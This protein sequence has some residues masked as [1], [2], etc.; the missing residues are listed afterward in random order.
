M[1][2]FIFEIGTKNPG[3]SFGSTRVGKWKEMQVHESTLAEK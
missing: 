1:Y 2:D 3:A